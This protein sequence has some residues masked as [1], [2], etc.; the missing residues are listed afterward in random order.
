MVV[1]SWQAGTGA[2]VAN[3]VFNLHISSI[4]GTTITTI[5]EV[6]GTSYLN[7]PSFSIS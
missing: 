3:K 4:L 7:T 5:T 6:S 2:D 1:F